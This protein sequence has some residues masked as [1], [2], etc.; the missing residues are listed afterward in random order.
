MLFV[1]WTIALSHG[2]LQ[3][4]LREPVPTARNQ[5]MEQEGKE[6]TRRS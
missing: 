5:F 3:G 6:A 4:D 2:L 1:V